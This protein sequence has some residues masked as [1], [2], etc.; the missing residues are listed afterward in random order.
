MTQRTSITL[1]TYHMNYQHQNKRSNNSNSNSNNGNSNN[2]SLA[3]IPEHEEIVITNTECSNSSIRSRIS[4]REEI[5][6][7]NMI[8][9]YLILWF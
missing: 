2:G 9:I 5:K 1:S 4:K 7:N 6:K 8:I 3:Y